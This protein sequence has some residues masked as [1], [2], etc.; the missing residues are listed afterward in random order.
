M[1]VIR[2]IQKTLYISIIFTNMLFERHSH[3]CICMYAYPQLIRKI[4]PSTL[5]HSA[6]IIV[7][8]KYRG[9]YGQFLVQKTYCFQDHKSK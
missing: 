5:L 2:Q 1:A 3:M 9:T 4:L 6:L 8:I 7:E